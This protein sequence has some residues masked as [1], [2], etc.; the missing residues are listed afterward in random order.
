[1]GTDAGEID[2]RCFNT[3]VIHSFI[4]FQAAWEENPHIHSKTCEITRNVDLIMLHVFWFVGLLTF[5][6]LH[7]LIVK[8]VCRRYTTLF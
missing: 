4:S 5:E 7:G 8:P 2:K 3:K 1:M 6:C